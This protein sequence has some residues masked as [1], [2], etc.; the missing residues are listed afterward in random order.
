MS[1]APAAHDTETGGPPSRLARLQYAAEQV[2]NLMFAVVFCIFVFKIVMRYVGHD[3]AAWTDEV[4]VILFIWMIFWAN[5]FVVDD[6][7]QIRFDLVY[8]PMPPKVQRAMALAR[9]V[10]VGGVFLWA[11]PT[12]IGYIMFLWRE[13]TP[14]LEW[15]L[16]YVYACFG[17][18]AV[19]VVLRAAV[20]I[21]RLIGPR[22]RAEL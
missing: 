13:R 10:L 4:C 15:R 8:R 19:M 22:W 21:V 1:G 18:F 9:L 16:D 14:V 11:L 3:E 7:R 17:L 2:S 6:H 5:A 12:S 20:G